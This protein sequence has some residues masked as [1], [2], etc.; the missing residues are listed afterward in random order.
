MIRKEVTG[1]NGGLLYVRVSNYIIFVKLLFLV[2]DA[3]LLARD[4]NNLKH[5]G[6]I[7]MVSGEMQW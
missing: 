4:L 7:R 5:K 3:F 1:T 6:M 2:L